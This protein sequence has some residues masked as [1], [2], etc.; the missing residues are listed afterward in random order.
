MLVSRILIWS[1][2]CVSLGYEKWGNVHLHVC[3][4]KNCFISILD[5]LSKQFLY[6]VPIVSLYYLFTYSLLSSLYC[7]LCFLCVF[8]CLCVC[9]FVCLCVCVVVCLRACVRACVRT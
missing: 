8:V 6:V 7:A 3:I 1:K 2:Y 4:H 5:F 9:V